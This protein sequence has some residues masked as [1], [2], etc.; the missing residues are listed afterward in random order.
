MGYLEIAAVAAALLAL[1]TPALGSTSVEERARLHYRITAR[2]DPAAQS[3]AVE[4]WIQRPPAANFYLHEDF[5][6]TRVEAD[7]KEVGFHED[8]AAERIAFLPIGVHVAVE[9]VGVRELHVAYEG[10]IREPV[11][12]VNMI[13]PDLVEMALYCAWLP[14]FEDLPEATFELE[15]DLPAGYVVIANGR[16]G[17]Q[18]SEGGRARTRWSSQRPAVDIVLVASPHFRRAESVSGSV[19][20]EV[21]HQQLPTELVEAR[22]ADLLE[23]RQWLEDVYGPPQG[24][25]DI[26]IVYA[27]RHGWGYY[28]PGMFVVSER[29][30]ADAAADPYQAAMDFRYSLHEIAHSWWSIADQATT[31]DWINEGLAEFSALSFCRECYGAEI[32]ERRVEEYRQEASRSTTAIAETEM[33]SPDQEANRHSKSP[34]MFVEAE[35]RFGAESLNEFLRSFYARFAGTRA[36]TTEAFLE[37]ARAHLGTDGEEFFR[38]ALFRK[39]DLTGPPKEAER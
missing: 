9:A 2:I 11:A 7:G 32:A 3:L 5:T 38:E 35:S 29:A 30:T 20:V 24:A 8:A 10:S 4:A 27:P 1:A 19:R 31:H 33:A 17:K 21:Y 37:E 13:T 16:Q 22:M 12:K 23:G 15:V 26:C 25:A 36:A 39:A 28:R 34:L 18:R 14:L 6:L